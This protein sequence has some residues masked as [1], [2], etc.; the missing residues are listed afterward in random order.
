MENIYATDWDSHEDHP[1]FEWDRIR[2]A[3]RLGGQMLGASIFVIGP[4][5]KS[6]PYHFHHSNEE[7]L[8]V[9][10]GSIT[11]RTPEGDELASRGDAMIF[12]KGP[13]GAHQMINSSD[14]EARILMISTMVEP[15]IAEY[16][17]TGKIGV[18][19]GRAPG[20]TCEASLWKFLD[21]S[22]EVGY[23]DGE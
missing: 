12:R 20:G 7:M 15:E 18:F 17:D 14:S 22:A 4:G 6:F 3:R 9:L 2:L 1:G 16:P 23:F 11:V 5:Q 13:E 19:A 21:G 8:I 10:D